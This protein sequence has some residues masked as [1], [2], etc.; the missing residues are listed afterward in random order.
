MPP[1]GHDDAAKG[2]AAGGQFALDVREELHRV[3]SSESFNT[4]E[5]NRQ[6]LSHIV[7]EALSGRAHRIKA[8]NIATSVFGRGENFDPQTDTIVRIEAGRLRS[9]LQH[10]YLISGES[11]S[12]R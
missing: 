10:F 5:R 7:T 8:Y 2:P 11:G 12:I 9:A 3:L 4:T 1:V 6:F